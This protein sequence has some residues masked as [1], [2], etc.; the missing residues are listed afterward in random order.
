METMQAPAQFLPR[1][2]LQ[3]L[4]DVLSARGYRVIGPQ[5]RDGA[6]M[7][8]D[9]AQ[10]SDL[11]RGWRDAQEPG[12]Y[13]LSPG[14]SVRCF[15]WANG[16]QA[17]KPY[18]FAAR[19]P[20]WRAVQTENGFRVEA[21]EPD[22]RPLAFI[23][24]RACDLAALTLQDQVFLAGPFVDPYYAA[25]GT[26]MLLIA[27]H[28]SHAAATCFCASTGDGPRA[29][30]G[31]DLALSELDEGFVLEVGSTTG[32]CIAALLPLAP[33]SAAQIQSA[34]TQVE[35]AARSQTRA[36][37][38]RNLRDLLFANL[39]HPRW[40]D[41]AARCLSCGNCT[42]VC[43]T[44]FCHA[45]RD[46]PALNGQDTVHLR[47]WDSCFSAGHAYIHGFQVRPE[48]KHRYRQWLTHK[49]GS[50]HEQFGRSGCVGCG[51]CIAWCPVGIDLTAEAQA[52]TVETGHDD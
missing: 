24:V 50:W 14:D 1:S 51:R 47:E 46:E 38:S 19:E 15:A 42:L 29:A 4:I 30:G 16:P 13:R 43:P 41:V 22:V 27:V 23:G 36:L 20:L 37:P 25:R 45:E 6:I 39:D 26:E 3:T 48:T 10:A 35:A 32:R 21:L 8:G 7:Y 28:C 44:C 40:D 11:P 5:V 12:R 31:F 52:I 2:A 18:L 34:Q 49:L 33:A 9:L 17:I